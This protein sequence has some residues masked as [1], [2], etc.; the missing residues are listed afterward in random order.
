MPS[1]SHLDENGFVVLD[2]DLAAIAAQAQRDR[3]AACILCDDDGYRGGTVCDHIDH[4]PAA[5]RG[6][7]LVRQALAKNGG[8][9]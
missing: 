5:R 9:R 2:V 1:D 4:R 6:M 3:I 7:E 8:D